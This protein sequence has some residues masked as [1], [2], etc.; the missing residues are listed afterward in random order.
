M[1]KRIYREVR[2]RIS[3][4]VFNLFFRRIDTPI[5]KCPHC[6]R[7]YSCCNAAKVIIK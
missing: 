3:V 7:T 5:C 1:M 6:E 2:R 4:L